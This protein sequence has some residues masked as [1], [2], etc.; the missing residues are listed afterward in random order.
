[1]NDVGD[2]IGEGMGAGHLGGVSVGVGLGLDKRAGRLDRLEGGSPLATVLAASGRTLGSSSAAEFPLSSS[3][4]IFSRWA[5]TAS[6][7][8]FRCAR[9]LLARPSE[10]G[11]ERWCGSEYCGGL[12]LRVPSSDDRRVAVSLEAVGISE[13]ESEGA[14]SVG[15]VVSV[16]TRT[17]SAPGACTPSEIWMCDSS[18][19]TGVSVYPR[20]SA[21]AASFGALMRQ[22]KMQPRFRLSFLSAWD[23][24]NSRLSGSQRRHPR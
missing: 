18:M 14:A 2:G 8:R 20:S 13:V 12:E 19:F 1:M 7:S 24:H 5:P 10:G 15:D 3:A 9:G 11:E 16:A 21:L 6:S 4:Q 17:V 23:F 22:R